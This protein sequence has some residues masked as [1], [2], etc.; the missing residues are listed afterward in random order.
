MQR[1][2]LIF[3]TV[4]LAACMQRP[5]H[6]AKCEP[7]ELLRAVVAGD[8]EAVSGCLKTVPA[9]TRDE[10]GCPA[11]ALAAW[12]GH[13]HIVGQLHAAGAD[14][15]A[16]CASGTNALAYAIKAKHAGLVKVSPKCCLEPVNIRVCQHRLTFTPSHTHAHANTALSGR[17]S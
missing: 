8:A 6:A 4:L 12:K 1:L 7:S 15:R 16:V 2:H 9:D 17:R 13:E 14:L 10:A 3:A 11:V 5:A